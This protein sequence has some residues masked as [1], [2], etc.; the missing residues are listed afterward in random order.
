MQYATKNYYGGTWPGST[1]TFGLMLDHH[2]LVL[3]GKQLLGNR[4]CCEHTLPTI[5]C[6]G[7]MRGYDGNW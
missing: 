1:L 3:G 6:A 7:F 4:L 5:P 2:M